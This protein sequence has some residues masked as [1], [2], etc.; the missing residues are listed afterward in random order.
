MDDKE[1]IDRFWTRTESAIAAI[2]E[3]YSGCC[4]KVAMNILGNAEDAEEVLNDTYS[5]IWNS[6]PPERP[7]NLRAY[8]CRI[9]RNLS[10]DRLRKAKAEKRGSGQIDAVLS[11]LEECVTNGNDAYSELADSDAIAAAINKFLSEQSADNRRIFVLR[12]WGAAGIE[13]IAGALGM[14][15]GNVRSALYRMRKKLKKHLESEG[16][17]L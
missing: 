6:I 4:H 14:T 3:K 9:A 12:Y 13:H 16:I 17:Y 11:E 8:V 15:N 2:G 10:F 5:R 1:I 7:D